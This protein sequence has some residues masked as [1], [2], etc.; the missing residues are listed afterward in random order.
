MEQNYMCLNV[1]HSSPSMKHP[2]NMKLKLKIYVLYALVVTFFPRT[3]KGGG[4][5]I[6]RFGSHFLSHEWT[7]HGWEELTHR[8]RLS[9]PG[10]GQQQERV[11][12]LVWR[13]CCPMVFC[14]GLIQQN[15]FQS[16][17]M[18]K[19]AAMTIRNHYT[20]E[21]EALPD[22]S[23]SAAGDPSTITRVIEWTKLACL[24]SLA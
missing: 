24:F 23:R 19:M 1:G 2:L 18:K 12:P 17:G 20:T 16:E 22:E 7:S 6:C 13:R 21:N 9:R 10:G 5:K 14:I 3:T 15:L 8:D 11:Y 4:K